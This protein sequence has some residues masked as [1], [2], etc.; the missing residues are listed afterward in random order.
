MSKKDH[1][2]A[3]WLFWNIAIFVIFIVALLMGLPSKTTALIA[4]I[5]PTFAVCMT[6]VA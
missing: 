5:T 2:K 6:N 1:Q 4:F 3:I